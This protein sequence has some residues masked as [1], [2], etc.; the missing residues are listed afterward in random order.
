MLDLRIFEEMKEKRP[1]PRWRR[2]KRLGVTEAKRR[3]EGKRAKRWPVFTIFLFLVVGTVLLFRPWALVLCFGFLLLLW[4]SYCM[5]IF[6][7]LLCVET[8]LGFPPSCLNVILYLV[9]PP[10][11]L[12]VMLYLVFPLF[13]FERA[14]VWW[15]VF[16]SL[17]GLLHLFFFFFFEWVTALVWWFSFLLLER[18]TVLGFVGLNNDFWNEVGLRNMLWKG[19]WCWYWGQVGCL[20]NFQVLDG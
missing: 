2:R 17:N 1:L 3:G 12:N 19:Q 9:F 11:C 7:L 16:L 14:T 8:A 4:M 6:L 13:F 5:M 18:D 10:S 15:F 20:R